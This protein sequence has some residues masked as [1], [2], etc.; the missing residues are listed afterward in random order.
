MKRKPTW[1]SFTN[2]H[3]L[4]QLQKSHRQSHLQPRLA[5]VGWP[6]RKRHRPSQKSHRHLHPKSGHHPLH[7]PQDSLKRPVP[8]QPPSRNS[9]LLPK[10]SKDRQL[11]STFPALGPDRKI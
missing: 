1:T 3:L 7:L 6:N 11:L 9:S 2:G 4:P 5:E 8:S 10:R